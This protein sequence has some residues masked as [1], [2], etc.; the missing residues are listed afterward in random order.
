MKQDIFRPTLQ[1]PKPVELTAEQW[2][3]I[4][5]VLDIATSDSKFS[6]KAIRALQIVLTQER[7]E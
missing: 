6:E 4:Q 1:K 3:A 7:S 5:R 2:A